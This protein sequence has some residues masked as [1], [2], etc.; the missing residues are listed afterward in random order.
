MQVYL[1]WSW[2]WNETRN[3]LGEHRSPPSS[4][5]PNMKKVNPWIFHENTFM[6][7]RVILLTDRGVNVRKTKAVCLHKVHINEWMDGWMTE[8]LKESLFSEQNI[9]LENAFSKNSDKNLSRENRFINA[10]KSQMSHSLYSLNIFWN[11]KKK[12]FIRTGKGPAADVWGP[13]RVAA[14]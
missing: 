10:L 8:L 7:F 14:W 3:A 2:K 6:A 13:C 11:I 5:F 9:Y 1:F 12:M 4:S